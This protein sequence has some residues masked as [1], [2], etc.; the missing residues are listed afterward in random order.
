MGVSWQIKNGLA[1]PL[2]EKGNV[3]ANHA[4]GIA[5]E[6]L[7]LREELETCPST[8][9]NVI[10]HHKDHLL[11][12]VLKATYKQHKC[13]EQARGGGGGGGDEE[14]HNIEA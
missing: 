9:I 7:S 14:Y 13:E 4:V 10:D 1:D 12:E 5:M 11:D 3:G 8:V 6:V 2:M